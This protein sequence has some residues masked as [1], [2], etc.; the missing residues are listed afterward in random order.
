MKNQKNIAIFNKKKIRRHWDDDEGLWY[1]SVIDVITVLTDSS[2]PK[3]YWTDLKRKLHQEGSEV[4]DKI[5]QLKFKAKDGK[6][7][8][9][10]CFS[11]E[12]MLR[13]VQTIPSPKAEP[14]KLNG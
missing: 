3:R 1:F 7:Y 2:I 9:T 8:E 14:L 6:K 4:Y 5:V 10:D 13:L 11:T 12:D